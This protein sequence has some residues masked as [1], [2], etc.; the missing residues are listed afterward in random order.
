MT[1][2]ALGFGFSFAALAEREGLI[3]LDKT[4]LDR[5]AASDPDLHTRLLA[6]R[7]A[8]DA[9]PAKDESDLIVAVGPHLDGFIATL[10]GIE[11][12]TQA[13]SDETAKLDPIHAC[14]RLFVQRQAVKKYADASTFDGPALTVVLEALFGEHLTEEAFARHVAAWEAATLTDAIDVALRYAAWATLTDAG[15]AAHKGGTLFRI[16]HRVDP[17][18]LVPVETIVRDGVTMLR[19]PE[20]EW[21]H[22]EGFALTD[23]GMNTQQA[24]DQVGYCIL[25][26]TQGKDSCSKG[27]KDRKTGTFQKSPFG[28]TLAGCPLECN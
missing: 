19:L 12:Q 21:R 11:A 10:F 2:F 1:D 16:P 17:Q 9:L 27:L 18:H 22:R 6:A 4:F 23:P 24:L 15:K 14:K 28:V 13:L 8:P 26:H 20:H 25:C 3:R 5:L 7:A